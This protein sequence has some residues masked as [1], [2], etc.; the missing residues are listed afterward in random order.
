MKK[1]TIV[2]NSTV[3]I[4]GLVPGGELQV[5]I[6]KKGTI[7]DKHWRRRIADN[8][9]AIEIKKSKKKGAK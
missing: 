1:L 8:D 6:D 4:H 2:N 5:D 7:I 9:G 3:T